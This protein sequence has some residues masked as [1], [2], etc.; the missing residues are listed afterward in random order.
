MKL[1]D[2]LRHHPHPL[3][4]M[5]GKAL[6]LSSPLIKSD[7]LYVRLEYFLEMGRRLNLKNPTTYN[8]K[9]QWLKLNYRRVDYPALVDKSTVKPLVEPII[10]SAHIIPTL[11]VWDSFDEIDFDKLPRGFVLKTTHDSG[12][13]AVIPDKEK[14]DKAALRSKIEHS[15]RHNFYLEHREYPYGAIK[16]RIMAEELIS[17]PDGGELRDYKFFC[18]DGEVRLLFVATDRSHDTRFDFFDTD[19]K[20]LPFT[21]GHPRADKLPGRPECFDGMKAMAAKLSKGHPHVRVD[22]YETGGKIYFGE[23]TFFHY[24]GCV[25]FNPPEWDVRL[26]EMLTLPRPLNPL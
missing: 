6:R 19:F 23:L 16:P 21:Q 14:M 22:L 4:W 11:G 5:A 20:P 18:F 17:E 3:R 7:R 13:V 24:A 2:K 10:D 25:E 26:G 15:L 1:I 8:E 9:L 12:G